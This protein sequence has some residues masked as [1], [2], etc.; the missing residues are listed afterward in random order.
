MSARV[1][2][3]GFQGLCRRDTAAA[4]A[5]QDSGSGLSATSCIEACLSGIYTIDLS[6]GPRLES[7]RMKDSF[8]LPEGQQIASHVNGSD[9]LL[10]FLCS[11]LMLLLVGRRSFQLTGSSDKVFFAN[12]RSRSKCLGAV[13]LQY[14]PPHSSK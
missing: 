5:F 8:I 4:D 7:P 10:L 12:I 9:T 14:S 6:L 3:L 13:L 2:I 11:F 1:Q